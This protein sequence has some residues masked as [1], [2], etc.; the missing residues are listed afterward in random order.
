MTGAL[1]GGIAGAL[2]DAGVAE[3]QAQRDAEAVRA[4]SAVIAVRAE[5]PEA[6]PVGRIQA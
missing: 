5:P 2:I 3:P 6:A 1:A 4:G